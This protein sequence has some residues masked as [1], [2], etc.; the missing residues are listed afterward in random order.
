M[1]DTS[2]PAVKVAA[3]AFSVK[4]VVLTSLAEDITSGR[5][6]APKATPAWPL[7]PSASTAGGVPLAEAWWPLP[8]RSAHTA[9][10]LPSAGLP[11]P[12]P[13]TSVASNQNTRPLSLGPSAGAGRPATLRAGPSLTSPTVMVWVWVTVS[14]TASRTCTV[15]SWLSAASWSM[16]SASATRTS[17][18][19][20]SMAKRPSASSVSVKPW[21]SPASGSSTWTWPTT[22]PS[23]ASSSTVALSSVAAIGASLTGVTATCSVP[24]VVATWPVAVSVASADTV[25]AKS[26]WESAGG[27]TVSVVRSQPVTSAWP[28][29]TPAVKLFAPS[30]STAPAGRPSMTMPRVS[31][32]SRSRSTAEMSSPMAVSSA[33][34]AS[35]STITGASADG[36]TVKR[37]V[38]VEMAPWLSVT[39]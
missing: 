18:V 35:L 22:W 37:T 19:V 10:P 15:M 12:P 25:S 13:S 6:V 29:S 5:S 23:A 30:D 31:D 20:S 21:L 14:P 4:L 32:P 3:N 11:V 34:A 24:V 39:M 2:A 16:R 26:A 7:T 27:V 38:P 8:D 33:P 9:T 17:P 36:S 1:P 28:A